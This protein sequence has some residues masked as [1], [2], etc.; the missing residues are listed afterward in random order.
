MHTSMLTKYIILLSYLWYVIFIPAFGQSKSV[1]SPYSKGKL[2]AN[3]GWNR[4]A[5]T[6]SD[7]KL[8]GADYDLLIKKIKANDRFT[9]ISYINYLK[10]N[11]VTI[12]QTNVRLGYFITHNTAIVLGLDH[13]KYVMDQDQIATVVGQITRPGIY[14][15]SYNEPTKLTQ[16]FL[17]YEH[18]DGLNY[19]HIG[20]EKYKN[21]YYNP[22]RTIIIDYIYGANIGV[23]LP[24]TNVQF[25]NYE[26]TDRYHLSGYG[27]QL[28][29]ALQLLFV[30]HIIL[31]MEADI[32]YI[33]MPNIIL[34][35]TGIPG[36]GKQNFGYAQLNWQIGYNFQF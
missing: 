5:F 31:R 15:K 16:D 14:Q 7:L 13:M 11:N 24:K 19:V 23:L 30:K 27:I 9:P 34:H 21:Q 6:K 2:F 32:G 4:D 3:W 25:L 33:N 18:T 20:I 12:P 1:I 36:K 28:R 8:K 35:K 17:L 10:L 29:N 26:R 22:K